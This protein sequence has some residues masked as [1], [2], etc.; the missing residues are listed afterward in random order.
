LSELGGVVTA[1]FGALD[2]SGGT[3]STGQ[4]DGP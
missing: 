3:S 4:N 2:E 1:A